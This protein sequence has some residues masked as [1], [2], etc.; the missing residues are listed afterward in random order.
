VNV[1]NNVLRHRAVNVSN[2]TPTLICPGNTGYRT[3]VVIYNGGPNPIYVGGPS[4]TIADG[5]YVGLQ[6]V[7]EL[8]LGP[9]VPL[10]AIAETAA[11][12]GNTNTRVLE[13]G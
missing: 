8:P 7:L 12:S 1:G 11:Q 4:V 3:H 2:T 13:I 5:M 10:Y 6:W 9:G